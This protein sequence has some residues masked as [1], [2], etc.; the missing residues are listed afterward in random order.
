MWFFMA[1]GL[2]TVAILAAEGSDRIFKSFN[3]LLLLLRRQVK[4][5][6]T[7]LSARAVGLH[8]VEPTGSQDP[9]GLSS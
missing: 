8:H 3:V 4:L 6:R 5:V 7:R 9:T 2:G 1:P